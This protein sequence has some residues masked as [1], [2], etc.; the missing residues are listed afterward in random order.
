M[1]TDFDNRLNKVNWFHKADL[2]NPFIES[3][4]V[5]KEVVNPP[6]SIVIISWQYNNLILQ[7]FESLN[8]QRHLNFELIFVNNGKDDIEFSSIL[9]YVDIYIKLNTNTGAYLARNIGAIYAQA[10][11]LLFL[12]D[13]GIAD[14]QLI[15]AHLDAY[16]LFDIISLRGVYQPLN[17][18]NKLNKLAKHYYLGSRPFPRYVDLEGNASYKSEAF[19]SVGGWSDEI[20]FGHGGL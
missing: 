18:D 6:I 5:R 2:Y 14:S 10:P 7:N 19:F 20:Q 15:Q 11:I 9:P 8:K 4:E 17:K 12:E 3:I 16:N 1:T 13:D